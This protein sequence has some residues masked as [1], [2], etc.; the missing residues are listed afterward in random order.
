MNM[1]SNFTL[2]ILGATVLFVAAVLLVNPF[3]IWMPE[4]VHMTMLAVLVAA[5]GALAVFV[6]RERATD[7]R[8]DAHRAFA[9]R[10]AFLAGSAVL[11]LGIVMQTFA[12][13]LDPWLV[14]ALLAMVLAK[15]ATRLWSNW[16]R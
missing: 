15:V 13:T 1:R 8:D 16:Y 6:V 12:H 3:H 9:G 4:M 11:L 14:I 5:V 10:A 2:E 7:E